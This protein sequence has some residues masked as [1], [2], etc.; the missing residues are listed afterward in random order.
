VTK[1]GL[2]HNK[3]RISEMVDRQ[4]FITKD[5]K[6]PPVSML[7]EE[8]YKRAGFVPPY[9]VFDKTMTVSGNNKNMDTNIHTDNTKNPRS[10]KVF[11]SPLAAQETKGSKWGN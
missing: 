6:D 11:I 7:K 2:R 10:R 5:V 3:R 1:I 9:K 8:E 4:I